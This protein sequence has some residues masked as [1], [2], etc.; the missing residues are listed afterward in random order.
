[1]LPKTAKC[2]MSKGD[3]SLGMQGIFSARGHKVT[4]VDSPN[5]HRMIASNKVDPVD[6]TAKRDENGEA[7]L[8]AI[9]RPDHECQQA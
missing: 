2:K 4:P 6:C 9:G 5:Q 3:L 1:M 7:F 8:S